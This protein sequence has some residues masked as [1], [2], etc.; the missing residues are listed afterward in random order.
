MP[1]QQLKTFPQI[2]QRLIA[3]TVARSELSDLTD[4]S[5]VRHILAAVAREVDDAYYQMTRVTDSFSIDRAAGLDLDERAR[6]IQPGTLRRLGPRRAQGLVVFSRATND[7]TTIRVNAGT[8]IKT[9]DGLIARTLEEAVIT[10]T[11]PEQVTGHGLGRDAAPVSAIMDTPGADGNVAIGAIT[12][13]VNRPA[14]I[15]EVTNSSAFTGGRDQESDDSFRARLK[16]FVGSLARNTV[17]ALEFVAVGIED[18]TTGSNKQVRFSH[19]FE[20]PIQRGNVTLYVDDGSG[21]ART[22]QTVTGENVTL[23]LVGPPADT[24][25]GGEEFLQLDNWP[26]DARV[27]FEI[28]L[29]ATP[30]VNNTDYFL[31]PTNGRIFFTTP[32]ANTDVVEADYTYFDGLIQEVQKVVDGDP[33]DR[34]NYPGWRAAGVR[35]VVNEPVIRNIEVEATLTLVLGTEF[36]TAQAAVE[37]AITDYINQLGISGDVVRN[38]IIERIMSVTGVSDVSLALPTG[39]INILDNEVARTTSGQISIT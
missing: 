4:S 13:F 25:V 19:A 34:A 33:A 17:E 28:R 20:D 23:G 29:N 22:V 8:A 31:D 30:L 1:Q 26:V 5:S 9:A 11:S 15:V 2:L 14:G 10:P 36:A 39:N 24:A 18:P 16:E 32:L 12:R 38:E 3:K 27:P 35:V 7:L 37:T 6:D 21:T